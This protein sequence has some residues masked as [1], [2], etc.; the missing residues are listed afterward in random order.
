M[1][2][3][4][5]GSQIEPIVLQF[6]YYFLLFVLYSFGGW[7]VEYIWTYFM[8]RKLENRGFLFGPICPIYGVGSL[9]CILLIGPL[10]LSWPLE[11]LLVIVI[12]DLI[13]YIT[14]VVL[15]KIYNV[16]WWDY[17]AASVLHLNGR[18]SLETSIGFG[19]GGIFI[20]HFIQPFFSRLLA[21]LGPLS[22]L[23][24]SGLLLIIFVADILLSL[25][26][27]SNIKG[28]FKGGTVD[29]T[30]EIKRLS[31]NYYKKASRLSRRL[32]HTAMHHVGNAQ[33]EAKRRVA[34]TF[35]SKASK[36]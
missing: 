36:K 7:I 1:F 18:V 2:F 19:V 31:I 6:A 28:A 24:I 29:L 34:T 20:L 10:R 9:V 17:T 13:E 26:A 32:V 22:L 11:F 30:A 4:L 21:P 15:E 12:C 35:R 25:I 3:N 27:I 5:P 23:A 33:K 16:R 8:K 14:S